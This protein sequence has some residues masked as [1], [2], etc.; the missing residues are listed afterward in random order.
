MR[1]CCQKTKKGIQLDP[2][3]G[4]WAA[5]ALIVGVLRGKR[6]KHPAIATPEGPETFQND[7]GPPIVLVALRGKMCQE[8]PLNEG[9]RGQ[10]IYYAVTRLRDYANALYYVSF[11][12]FWLSRSRVVA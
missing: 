5:T 1:F 2:P 7:R 6:T 9:G 12:N 11:P 8:Y 4:V 10:G 3:K